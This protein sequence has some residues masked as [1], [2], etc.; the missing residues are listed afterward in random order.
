MGVDQ[1]S[2]QSRQHD[3]SQ[4]RTESAAST[5]RFYLA[6]LS[7]VWITS[8]AT[9]T[10]AAAAAA[11]AATTSADA[12]SIPTTAAADGSSTVS[13][14]ANGPS[15]V[16][17]TADGPSAVSATSDADGSSTV[18]AAHAAVPTTTTATADV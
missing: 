17:T 11:T 4:G 3:D 16:P 9:A 15:T 5:H 18:P 1:G 13:A 14:T 12:I 10:K 8:D 7:V 2:H 6:R